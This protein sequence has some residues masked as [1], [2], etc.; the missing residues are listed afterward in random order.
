MESEASPQTLC[1]NMCHFEKKNIQTPVAA[2][3]VHFMWLLGSW[4]V[5]EI[6]VYL[7]RLLVL[8]KVNNLQFV[9]ICKLRSCASQF[10]CLITMIISQQI[11]AFYFLS[12]CTWL[13]TEQFPPSLSNTYPWVIISSVGSAL[14][15]TIPLFPSVYRSNYHSR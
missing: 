5:S 11:S 15:M 1:T 2:V 13:L 10:A 3:P 14:I 12:Q 9:Q 7:S 6:T 8:P 4:W